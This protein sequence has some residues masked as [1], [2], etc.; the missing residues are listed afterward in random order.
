MAVD[1]SSSNG[2]ARRYVL[3]VLRMTSCFHIMDGSPI[4]DNSNVSSYS[5]GGGISRSSDSVVWSTLQ[6]AAPEVK[7]A[8]SDCILFRLILPIALQ[9]V[10][11]AARES[12][13]LSSVIVPC[14]ADVIQNV[15]ACVLFRPL[16]LLL[17]RLR[18]CASFYGLPD[19]DFVAKADGLYLLIQFTSYKQLFGVANGRRFE[20]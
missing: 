17:F 20:S 13:P 3:P 16:F 6:V 18:N 19:V 10:N 12:A 15:I 7:S 8:I 14:C 4:K 2:N 11:R 1:R 5:P 9:R